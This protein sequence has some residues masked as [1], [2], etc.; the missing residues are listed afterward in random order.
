MKT[1]FGQKI[2][3]DAFSS[4]NFAE[5]STQKQEMQIYLSIVRTINDFFSIL[6]QYIHTRP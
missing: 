3:C 6:K 5:T 2:F 1:R 4:W